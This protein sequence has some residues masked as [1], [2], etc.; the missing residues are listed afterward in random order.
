M[1]LPCLV[2]SVLLNLVSAWLSAADQAV[3]DN[4]MLLESNSHITNDEIRAQLERK[5]QSRVEE[6]TTYSHTLKISVTNEADLSPMLNKKWI[7]N[8][9][10]SLSFKKWEELHMV[11]KRDSEKDNQTIYAEIIGSEKSAVDIALGLLKASNIKAAVTYHKHWMKITFRES[12]DADRALRY[13]I[14]D[15]E[16]DCESHEFVILHMRASSEEARLRALALPNPY[17]MAEPY[18]DDLRAQCF[19]NDDPCCGCQFQ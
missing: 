14:F 19:D 17:N 2:L 11:D 7:V 12:A 16:I 3:P 10:Y 8:G 15:F 18:H 13:I 9:A 6:M 5:L 1:R 4:C